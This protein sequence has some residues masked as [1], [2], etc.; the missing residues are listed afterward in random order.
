MRPLIAVSTL[1]FIVLTSQS[2][3]AQHISGTGQICLSTPDGPSLCV[4]QT[5][6]QCENAKLPMTTSRCVDRSIAEGTVGSGSGARPSTDASSPTV[7][8]SSQR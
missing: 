4:F 6:A 1:T 5:M 7:G 8:G 3:L 2:A